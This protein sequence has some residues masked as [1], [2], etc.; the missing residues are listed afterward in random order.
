MI[1]IKKYQL[2]KVM[3]DYSVDYLYFKMLVDLSKH[4]EL[5]TDP[6]TIK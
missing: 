6:N 5:V 2:V 4:L 3:V 1:A